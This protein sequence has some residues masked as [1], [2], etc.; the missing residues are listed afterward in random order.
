M[1]PEKSVVFCQEARGHS[2]FGQGKEGGW[3][4]GLAGDAAGN[5]EQEAVG[6]QGE[7]Y[8]AAEGLG[9]HSN[10]ALPTLRLKGQMGT[11][12]LTRPRLVIPPGFVSLQVLE[13]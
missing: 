2:R 6:V 10:H 4:L 3:L 8:P 9:P 12:F 11:I 1:P 5:D 13:A 7:D